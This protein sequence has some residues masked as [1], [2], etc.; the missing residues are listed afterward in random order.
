MLRRL[1][2]DLEGDFNRDWSRWGELCF[3]VIEET[4]LE[5]D[6]EVLEETELVGRRSRIALSL[7]VRWANFDFLAA[8]VEKLALGGTVGASDLGVMRFYR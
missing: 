5:R 4:E 1:F 8:A 3:F 7:G 6:R 2:L